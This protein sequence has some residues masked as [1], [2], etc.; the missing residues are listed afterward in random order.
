MCTLSLENS[1]DETAPQTYRH[2]LIA[3]NLNKVFIAKS[4]FKDVEVVE[5]FKLYLLVFK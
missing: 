4:S 3:L 5:I 2:I 1:T